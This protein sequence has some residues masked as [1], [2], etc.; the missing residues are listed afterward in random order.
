MIQFHFASI[1]FVLIFD[2]LFLR[3]SFL[4]SSISS[5][6]FF[7]IFPGTVSSGV[8]ISSSSMLIL[9]S[10]LNMLNILKSCINILDEFLSDCNTLFLIL[11]SCI[12]ILVPLNISSS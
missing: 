8:S 11:S 5:L 12:D 9:Y 3:F 10:S 7:V 2:S 6:D 1:Q 4:K